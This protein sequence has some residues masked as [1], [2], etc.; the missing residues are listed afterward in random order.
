MSDNMTAIEYYN[1]L[2]QIWNFRPTA[3]KCNGYESIMPDLAAYTKVDWDRASFADK[4]RIE[5]EVFDLYRSVN[6]VP[7]EYYSFD[8]CIAAIKDLNSAKPK[9]LNK[10]LS[11][12][13]REGQDLC[14]FW[15]PNMMTATVVGRK[16]ADLRSR[17][18]NDQDLKTAINLCFR[19]R[20]ASKITASP[21]NIRTTLALIGG[22]SIQNFKP[23]NARAIFEEINP[24]FFGSVFDYSAG[25]GGRLLGAATSHLKLS[26]TGVEPN[27]ETFTGL[28]AL[29]DLIATHT[30]FNSTIVNSG[31]EVELEF[32]NNM[33]DGAFSSPPYFNL[34]KYC[35]EPTQCMVKFTTLGDW[36]DGYV[37]PTCKNLH[38]I[39]KPDAICA[40]NLANYTF[41]KREFTIEEEWKR[42][43][44]QTGFELV[45]T[46]YIGLVKRPGDGQHKQFVSQKAEPVYLFRNRKL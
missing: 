36:V 22:G 9:L 7:I 11:V 18:Y 23:L 6:L 21:S 30:G 17:F 37:V 3:L 29:S 24:G 12:N 13:N 35:D 4:E 44:E 5:Q 34:E 15:F 31:S 28:T 40:V 39:L 20:G 19:Y 16:N 38:R 2:T 32:E 8:G 10:T 41:R 27:T 43:A 25:Y 45:D 46:L 1:Y 42:A 14:R 33:F 26:Y